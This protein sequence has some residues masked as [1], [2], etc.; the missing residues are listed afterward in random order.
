MDTNVDF[1]TGLDEDIE[2]SS[3]PRTNIG[4]LTISAEFWKKGDKDKGVKST[5]VSQEEFLNLAAN[6]RFRKLLFY[7]DIREFAPSLSFDYTPKGFLIGSPDWRDILCPS[8]EAVYGAGSMKGETA[9]ATL[10]KL[11]NQY[12]ECEN[13]PQSSGDINPNTQKPYTT[14]RLLKVYES[15]NTAYAEHEKRFPKKEG[16]NGNAPAMTPSGGLK[17]WDAATWRQQWKDI[18]G[19][20]ID[21]NMTIDELVTSYG[22]DK[23]RIEE[24]LVWGFME[25]FPSTP[26]PQLAVKLH[27]PVKRVAEL[28]GKIDRIPF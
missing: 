25:M 6:M 10:R 5:Q 22:E 11:N 2:A 20:V 9:M 7:V 26:N 4:K 21:N 12:V 15:R 18:V 16:D 27:M 13:V 8:V 3:L 23:E 17:T 14:F 1:L 19:C 28:A 24:A